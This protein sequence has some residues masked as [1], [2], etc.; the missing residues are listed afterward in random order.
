[1]QRF[2]KRSLRLALGSAMF[3]NS[4]A[5]ASSGVT[6]IN[7]S[8]DQKFEAPRWMFDPKAKVKGGPLIERMVEAKKGL[9]GKDRTRC[10]AAIQKTYALGKSLGP[11]LAWNHLQCALIKDKKGALSRE[12]LAAIVNKVGAQPTWLLY[13]PSSHL[14]KTSY[15]S[16]LLALAELQS[17]AD[18]PAA[19][20]TVNKLQQ[21]RSWL[22]TEERANTYRWAGELAFVEQ[23]LHAAQDFLTRS[24]SEKENAEIRTRVESI[25]STLLGNKAP[26]TPAKATGNGNQELGVSDTEKD[27][28]QRL[29]HSIEAQD[30]VSAIEDGV[31]LIEKFPGSRHAS[32]AAD[33]ILDI[34]LSVSSRT[35]EKFRH[36][37]ESVVR[38][39]VKVDASRMARWANN[40]YARQNYTD[41]LTLAE[42]AFTK[43]GGQPESTKM[44]LLAGKAAMAS[45]EVSDA[46]AA[47]ERLLKQSS[48]TAEAVDATFRLGLI[49]F[50]AK[51]YS[52]AAAYL[53]R[54]L[55]LSGSKDY[56]YRALYWQWRAQQ[57]ID[58]AKSAAFAEPL[59]KKFPMS[60]YGLRAKAELNGNSLALP[61]NPVKVKAEFRLLET[62]RL[63]WE[64]LTILLKAGWFKE[65]EKELE[66][67]PAAQSADERLIRAKLWAS[68][69]RYDLAVQN[70]NR[71]IDE[72]PE[73]EQTSVLKI[74]FP[75]EFGPWIT[76]ESKTLNLGE[77][78]IRSLIRQEST[79]R[80]D[81][82]SSSNAMGVM[83]LLPATATEVAH[84]VKVKDF[85]VPESLYDP[86][87]NIKL[88]S[89]YLA[90]MFKNFGGNIPL[91]L[92]AY[93]AGPTRLR[94]WLAARK[95]MSALEATNSSSPEV[96]LWIDELPWEETSFYVK[97]ILR[98]WLI[99]R[100]LDGS[101]VTL[102][103]PIWLEAK[104]PVR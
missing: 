36:V 81:A 61:N 74:V 104:A 15:V 17:K 83:Q 26:P 38:E 70:V 57:K 18:R 80:P 9:I 2:F 89:T 46:S 66:S 21:V 27:I 91:G 24:L 55:A 43:F 20:K 97:A 22:T 30:Y 7:V 63:A 56:E 23:N 35:D 34:Y 6:V 87:I 84:D 14:L 62:E 3:L 47:F 39:M 59:I 50:R 101:K 75:K 65:G 73:L 33:K 51:R 4:S 25:R 72:N 45:G 85:Q 8:L 58:M 11:W 49:E 92:A 28:Y 77:D 60:Y 40:A 37:R 88:G 42:K 98:N 1:M 79:F 16:A 41:A 93:N 64:R 103:E 96:E 71:A 53:E 5:F 94:R 99:Y 31:E 32:E 67:L 68:T 48:G 90:R 10:L 76:R 95:D 54:L 78:W 86:D 13:G 19:W 12:A 29:T 102:T 44:L 82:K 100:M 69:L 52:R